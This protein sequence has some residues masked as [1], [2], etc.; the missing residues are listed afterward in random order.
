MWKV[1]NIAPVSVLGVESAYGFNITTERGQPLVFF[2]YATQAAAEAAAAHVRLAIKE[3][4]RADRHA[5]WLAGLEGL[6]ST[7]AAPPFP[8]K[9][10]EPIATLSAS[11]EAA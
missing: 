2:A 11:Q 6:S 1:G 10:T 3:L 8:S 5:L 7:D 9:E 4:L